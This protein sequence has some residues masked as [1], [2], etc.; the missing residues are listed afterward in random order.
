M[1]FDYI[2]AIRID[3]EA[4]I[5]LGQNPDN[6]RRTKHI[7]ARHFFAREKVTEGEVAAES[8]RTELQVADALTKA[9]LG[10]R[11]KELMIRMGL[12]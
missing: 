7:Q 6:H 5:C 11:L 1:G 2:P 10:P 9:P 12:G 3:N 8:V 4:A